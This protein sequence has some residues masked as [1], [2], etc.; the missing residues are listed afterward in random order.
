MTEHR[1][2]QNNRDLPWTKLIGFIV[3]SSRI[4][5]RMNSFFKQTIK[6]HQISIYNCFHNKKQNIYNCHVAYT[7]FFDTKSMLIYKFI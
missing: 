1:M 7:Y 6:G 3:G 4:Q 5:C 2:G